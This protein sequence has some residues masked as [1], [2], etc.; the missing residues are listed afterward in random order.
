MTWSLMNSL[1]KKGLIYLEENSNFFAIVWIILVI[2]WFT[3]YGGKTNWY[4]RP[5]MMKENQKVA[6]NGWLLPRRILRHFLQFYYIWAWSDNQILNKMWIKKILIFHC[7]IVFRI[8][9]HA[10]WNWLSG[11]I[12]LYWKIKKHSKDYCKTF[13]IGECTSYDACHI[14]CEKMK[15]W[16]CFVCLCH[17]YLLSFY[18]NRYRTLKK[19]NG[20]RKRLNC[21]N[22][23]WIHR[24]YAWH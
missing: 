4:V 18:K 11:S 7:A 16:F 2:Q 19:W 12:F 22:A 1:E 10:V 23:L 5:M 8:M 9:I 24:T 21:S 15:T 6:Q 14:F 20:E 17:A 3:W 13:Q